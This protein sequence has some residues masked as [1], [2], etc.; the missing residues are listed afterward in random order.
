[1]PNW[2]KVVVSGSDALL[3]TVTTTGDI[4]AGGDVIANNYI[5]NSTVTNVTQSFSSGSTIFGDSNDDTHQFTGS[6]QILGNTTASGDISS[7]GTIT[8]DTGDFNNLHTGVE[9]NKSPFGTNTNAIFRIGAPGLSYSTQLVFRQAGTQQWS[10][11]APVKAVYNSDFVIQHGNGNSELADADNFIIKSGSENVGI[12][13]TAGNDVP[14]KLTVNG[15]ISGSGH[16]NI[17]GNITGSGTLYISGN[18]FFP[19][20]QEDDDSGL[21]V[22]V[23]DP[24]SGKLYRTGSYSGIGGS[25]GGL[26]KAYGYV[27]LANSAGNIAVT[28]DAE[29]DGLNYLQL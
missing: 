29:E 4:T 23:V 9:V 16:L 19:T 1:M 28:L 14:E 6:I 15:N 8:A 21:K 3:N 11:G 2:K 26:G 27:Q 25:G 17:E 12:G 20:L 10:V 13:F 18:V 7:S 22:V 5:I 24:G